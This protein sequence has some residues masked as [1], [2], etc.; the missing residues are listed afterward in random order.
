MSV[1]AEGSS[2]PVWLRIQT[3]ATTYIHQHLQFKFKSDL[4]ELG[5]L[6]LWCAGALNVSIAVF[7]FVRI[8]MDRL[9]TADGRIIFSRQQ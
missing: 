7:H 6:P 2:E 4:K 3:L 8:L 5:A 1:L 9:K